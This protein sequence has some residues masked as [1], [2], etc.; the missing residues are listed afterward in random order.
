MLFYF[1]LKDLINFA[2]YNSF[3]NSSSV[4]ASIPNVPCH[5]AT[6]FTL[7]SLTAKYM[8]SLSPSA[9]CVQANFLSKPIK[10]WDVV[11]RAFANGSS[12]PTY[13]LPGDPTAKRVLMKI[14]Y[15]FKN[16]I[17]Y[18]M[19]KRHVLRSIYKILLAA[20]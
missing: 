10:Y 4:K 18:A 14:L 1:S 9:I 17:N 7:R 6:C 12:M 20:K 11:S 13:N 3:S 16:R 5:I 8:D 19:R 2:Y 15:I